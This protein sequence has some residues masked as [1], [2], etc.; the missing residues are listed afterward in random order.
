[1]AKYPLQCVCNRESWWGVRKV[2]QICGQFRADKIV[3]RES[4][5]V[6]C[7]HD[8]ACHL[9]GLDKAQAITRDAYSDTVNPLVRPDNG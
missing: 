3:G 1:M 8:L 2:P 6:S 5:C 9:S 4:Y 7:E